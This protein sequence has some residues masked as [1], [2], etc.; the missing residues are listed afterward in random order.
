MKKISL[1][2]K[3]HSTLAISLIVFI[4]ILLFLLA[5]FVGLLFIQQNIQIPPIIYLPIFSGALL[6]IF[7][8]PTD[9]TNKKNTYQKRKFGDFI[10]GMAGFMG[11]V[12]ILSGHQEPFAFPTTH[13]YNIVSSQRMVRDTLLIKKNTPRFLSKTPLHKK[14]ISA[15]AA[16]LIILTL[17][18]GLSLLVILAALVCDLSCSGNDALA[19]MLA[20]VGTAGI[21]GGAYYLIKKIIHTP[22]T[23][24]A[25]KLNFISK[26]LYRN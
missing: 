16:F 5:Y 11:I 18:V 15:G 9:G 3:R 20:I 4:K 6:A 8:Y 10:I 1:W 13:A 23:N 17:I 2:A 24:K 19:I 14:D 26:L 22:K 7:F 21:I 12:L 25:H